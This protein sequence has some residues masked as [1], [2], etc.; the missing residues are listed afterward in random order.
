MISDLPIFADHLQRLNPAHEDFVPSA[1]ALL[2]QL[3]PGLGS[4]VAPAIFAFFE[5]YSELDISSPGSFMLHLESF[6][7]FYL[8]DLV[9]SLKRHPSY[10]GVIMGNRALNSPD[11][12]ADVRSSLFQALEEATA[13]SAHQKV[14]DLACRFLLRH[15]SNPDE[16]NET[17]AAVEDSKF[18]EWCKEHEEDPE[19]ENAQEFFREIKEENGQS[20]WD[21]LDEDD[22]SGWE[23]NMNKD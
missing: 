21:N 9:A 7:P 12:P 18:V 11:C 22:R 23:D 14:K 2:D 5:R 1:E 3:A 4:S 8:G 10:N 15:N 19:D 13:G 20:F 6:Y 17:P 16:E